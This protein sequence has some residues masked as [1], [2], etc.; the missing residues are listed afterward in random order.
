MASTADEVAELDV[1]TVKTTDAVDDALEGADKIKADGNSAFRARDFETALERYTLAIALLEEARAPLEAE[2]P[3]DADATSVD[4]GATPEDAG[5]MP[6]DA[7]AMPE[8]EDERTERK[9][10]EHAAEDDQLKKKNEGKEEDERLP[11]LRERIAVLYSNRGACAMAQEDYDAAV[12]DCSKALELKPAYLKALLRRAAAE[13]KLDNLEDALRD[14][15]E[16][17]K[18]DPTNA[19]ARRKVPELQPIVDQRMEK[20]KEETLGKLKDLGNSILGN[21]GLS[22]DNFQMDQQ[23]G[24]GYNISFK[25]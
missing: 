21:F 4:A 7:G 14:Y 23:P 10:A 19:V 17:L 16:A 1:S 2:A 5:A 6:V 8:S 12:S 15:K 20:L 22:L 24:G 3:V 13:E 25:Q 18:L 9:A 11:E